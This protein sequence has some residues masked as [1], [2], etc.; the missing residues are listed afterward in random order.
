MVLLHDPATGLT[1][2]AHTDPDDE[3]QTTVLAAPPQRLPTTA[4]LKSATFSDGAVWIRTEEGGLWLAPELSATGLS[5][6]YN[7]AAR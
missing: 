3:Q 5:W 7:G 4:P 2:V 6:G 1:A